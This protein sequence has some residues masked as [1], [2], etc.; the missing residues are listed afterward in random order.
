MRQLLGGKKVRQKASHSRLLRSVV[1]PLTLRP[2]QL[3]A[4]IVPAT[5]PASSFADLIDLSARLGTLLVVLCS[6]RTKLSHVTKHVAA[7][8]GA[9]ALVIDVPADFRLP[10]MPTWTSTFALANGGRT[11]DLSLKRNLGLQLARLNGWSKVVFLDDDIT[12]RDTSAFTRLARHLDNHQIAGMICR[13][14]PDNSVV[15]HARRVA[16]LQQ[17]NFVSGS[18][19]GVHCGDLPLPFFPDIYNEDWFFFSKAVARHELVSVGDTT[20]SRYYPFADPDRARHEEFG[21]LLAEGLYALIED[22]DDRHLPYHRMLACADA[23]YWSAFIGARHESLRATRTRLEGFGAHTS[24]GCEPDAALRSLDAAEEQLS[25]ITTGLCMDFVEAWQCDLQ[26]WEATCMKT[27]NAGSVREAM[28]QFADLPWQFARF[29]DVHV[30]GA[31]GR[32]PLSLAGA[33]SPTGAAVR[34]DLLDRVA[35]G[36]RR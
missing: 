20:Q 13:D 4:I 34:T 22:V 36:A 25:T 21:D 31:T 6:R 16:G 24:G 35:A 12:L 19:L 8:P 27:N 2:S 3:N 17:D 33:Q 26:D 32:S 30:D 1:E 28:A 10:N 18:A 14:Y 15:C 5:R 7:T 11:S 23:K 29:G 9:K